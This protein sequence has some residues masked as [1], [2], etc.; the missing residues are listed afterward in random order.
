ML[1]KILIGEPMFA[2]L[3]IKLKLDG[4]MSVAGGFVLP[5]HAEAYSG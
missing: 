4:M 2:D 5:H 3:S 1:G